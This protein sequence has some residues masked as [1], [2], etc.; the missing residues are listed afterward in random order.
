VRAIEHYPQD[1][2]STLKSLARCRRVS[3]AVLSPG[4][5]NSAYFE[6]AFLPVRW[7][8]LVEGP[9]LV[10]DNVVYAGRPRG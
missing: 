2:L 9:I 10:N 8:R 4:V 5:F 1:L 6:H 7:R 3:L